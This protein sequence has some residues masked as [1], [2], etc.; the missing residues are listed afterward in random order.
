MLRAMSNAPEKAQR[1][2]II[3]VIAFLAVNVMFFLLSNSYFDSHRQMVPGVGSMPAFSPDQ[4][5]TIRISFAAFSFI[6]VGAGVLGAMWPRVIGHAIPLVLGAA[7]LISAVVAFR[8][9]ATAVLWVMLAIS[10]ILLPVLSW[11]SF[12]GS[13]ASW[14]F[15]IAMCAVLASVEFFGAPKVRGALDIGLWLTL[16]FPG[17]NSVAVS[18]LWSMNHEYLDPGA[19]DRA[20]TASA[21]A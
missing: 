16:I 7:H 20:A 19:A 5:S 15:L 8:H 18:S 2:A 21:T 12:K 14:A 17:L 3:A 10:G 1:L 13:R 11:L 4:I 6:V 9:D